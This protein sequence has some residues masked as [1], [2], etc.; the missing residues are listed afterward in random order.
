MQEKNKI[1]FIVWGEPYGKKNMKPVKRGGFMTQVQPKA[2]SDYMTMVKLSYIEQCKDFMFL[3]DQPLKVVINA[4][5]TPPKS[6]SKKKYQQMLNNEIRPI[7]KPDCDNISKAICD[8]LNK[9]AFA[10]DSA[11]VEL[12]VNKY[13]GER[14]RVEV[15]IYGY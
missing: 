2:N 9:L 4:Y 6:V 12:Q 13:Y 8:S 10:D 5:K 3:I 14:A 7:T 11:I 1:S 15:E